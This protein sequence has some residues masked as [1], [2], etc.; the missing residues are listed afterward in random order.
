MSAIIF[1]LASFRSTLH[2]SNA[3][4]FFSYTLHIIACV[5]L[6]TGLTERSICAEPRHDR[7]SESG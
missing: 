1:R 2:C 4:H 3:S 6:S 5:V 7:I